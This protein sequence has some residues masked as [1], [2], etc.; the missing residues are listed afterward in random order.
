[1]PNKPRRQGR[2]GVD[3]GVVTLGEMAARLTMLEVTCNRCQRHGLLSAGRLMA[4]HGA[5][6]PMPE[7]GGIVAA[8]CQRM[9]AGHIHDTCGVHVPQ[10]SKLTAPR[11]R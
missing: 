9:Q 10:L 2:S 11:R 7:L 3:P 1:M 8:D 5:A 6:L 4:E